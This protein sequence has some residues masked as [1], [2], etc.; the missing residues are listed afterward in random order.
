MALLAV[1][2]ADAQF[3]GEKGAWERISLTARLS[4]TAPN[5]IF[6][7]EWR[8]VYFAN[9]SNRANYELRL[10]EGQNRFDVVWGTVTNGN[11]SATGGVQKDDSVVVQYFCNGIGGAFTGGQSYTLQ[12]TRCTPTP[13]P[14]PTP[15]PRP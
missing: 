3:F 6:N 7:I 14:R 15:A 4:G 5:R 12:L 2:K 13:R 1:P 10:Y 11:I 8:T 9:P